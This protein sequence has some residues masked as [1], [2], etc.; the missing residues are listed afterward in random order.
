[1]VKISM[2][3][4]D[5]EPDGICGGHTHQAKNLCPCSGKWTACI[6]ESP[7]IALRRGRT[8]IPEHEHYPAYECLSKYPVPDDDTSDVIYKI[9]CGDCDATYVGQTGRTLKTRVAEHKSCKE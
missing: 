9:S 5:N 8:R 3:S 6:Y 2:A 1:M 4:S 7:L